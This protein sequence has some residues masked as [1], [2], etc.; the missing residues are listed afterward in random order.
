VLSNLIISSS[1]VVISLLFGC[2]LLVVWWHYKLPRHVA[3]WAGSFTAAALGHGL[4]TGSALLPG[5]DVLFAML[6]CHASVS[7]FSLL[8]WGFRLREQATSG[9]RCDNRDLDE[10]VHPHSNTRE[11]RARTQIGPGG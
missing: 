4:R 1:I 8:A 10:Q 11:I 2:A 5:Q 7:G 9:N 3:L 6:A